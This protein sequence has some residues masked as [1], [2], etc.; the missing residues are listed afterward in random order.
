VYRNRAGRSRWYT[1]KANRVLTPDEVRREA[2]DLLAQIARGEDPAENRKAERGAVTIAE[3]CREYL[4]KAEQGLLLIRRGSGR[5]KAKKPSTLYT[6]RSRING[7]I[8]PLIGHRT[9]RDLTT[10]DVE[11]FLEQ[12]IA[13]KAR[14]DKRT[15]ARGR[16]I[17]KGGRGAA[18]R[19]GGL[20]GG[21]LS[22][23]VSKGYRPENPAK[24]V[25][26]PADN[27]RK[28]RLEPEQ[29]RHL[30]AVL[31]AAEAVGEPWQ[32]IEALRL[33]TLSGGRLGDVAN[34]K[35]SECDLPGSC[36][37]LGDTKTGE[38]VRPL[39]RAAVRVL[40]GT[41]ARSKGDYVFPAIRGDGPYKGHAKARLRIL[42]G[43]DLAWLTPH[44]LR[45]SF[46]SIADDLGYTEATIAAMLGHAGGGV[47]RGYIHK[48]DP[49]LIAAAD[50]V[51]EHIAS[52]MS[53]TLASAEV[54]EMP[55]AAAG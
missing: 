28:V 8:I 14:S 53:G 48:L 12:V 46:A 23:A 9:V 20:L 39:G 10:R 52:A 31:A 41:L 36:L 1:I 5:G 45:H 37:R 18:A 4:D 7:H 3:L 42:K 49:A 33:L 22:Y 44:G 26:R 16:S 13:G 21:I 29:Y 15:K 50:R 35:R 24:G 30:G 54:I 38:S 19:T 43:T 17:V 32:A 55:R 34:L 51:A 47:T 25:V 27:K 6:D 2:R 11:T 40:E